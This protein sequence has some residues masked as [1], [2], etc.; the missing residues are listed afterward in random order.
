MP[1]LG[2]FVI[3]LSI[4]SIL[5]HKSSHAQDD[6]E[7]RFW[8]KELEANHTRKKDLSGLPYINIPLDDFPIGKYENNE[9]KI[10]EQKINSLAQQKI[11]NLGTQTNTDLKI[12]YGTANLEILTQYEQNFTM[13]CQTLVSYAKCL[14]TLGFSEDAQSVLEYGI[15]IGSDLSRNYLMLAELYRS[16]GKTEQIQ[17]LLGKAEQLDSLMK[18]SITEKLQAMLE[19]DSAVSL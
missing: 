4:L 7:A 17:T 10:Y 2:L 5:R 3:F 14:I 18:R 8:Q 13:L 6:A 19:E 16:N 11:V 9:L 15:S 1:I 12:T